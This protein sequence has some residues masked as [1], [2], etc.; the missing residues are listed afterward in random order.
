VI[1]GEAQEID[2]GPPQGDKPGPHHT[3]R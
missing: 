3:L 2:E 1:E